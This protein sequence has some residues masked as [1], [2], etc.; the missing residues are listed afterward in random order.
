MHVYVTIPMRAPWDLLLYSSE[1]PRVCLQSTV[2]F[3]PWEELV[4]LL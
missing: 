3:G 1:D 4:L 2:E